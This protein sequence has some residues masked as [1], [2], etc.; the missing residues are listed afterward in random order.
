MAAAGFGRGFGTSECPA[1]FL[2]PAT[3][4][5]TLAEESIEGEEP[6]KAVSMESG[7]LHDELRRGFHSD[8]R[9]ALAEWL[10]QHLKADLASIDRKL[11]M[12]IESAKRSPSKKRIAPQQPLPLLPPPSRKNSRA[13]SSSDAAASVASFA[14]TPKGTAALFKRSTTGLTRRSE[15]GAPNAPQTGLELVLSGKPPNLSRAGTRALDSAAMSSAA[16]MAQSN[17]RALDAMVGVT[18]RA[19]ALQ[20]Y[21][22]RSRFLRS[23]SSLSVGTSS[24]SEKVITA[25]TSGSLQ[26]L[27]D[28]DDMGASGSNITRTGNRR[29]SEPD[30]KDLQ[31]AEKL[32]GWG[33]RGKVSTTLQQ[34]YDF[35]DNPESSVAARVNAVVAPFW[36]LVT[37]AMTLIQS[38]KDSPF[39]GVLAATLE[40]VVF[41]LDAYNVI[42]VLAALPL[43][44]RAFMGFVM[45]TGEVAS[46]PHAILLCGVPIIRL[47]K[48]LRRFE[49]F[50]LILSA[51]RSAAEALPVLLFILSIIALTFSMLIYLVEPRDSIE[52]IPMSLWLTIVTMS[53]VGYGDV[54][55]KTSLGHFL[56]SILIVI[57]ALYIAIP[58]GIVGNA[59]SATWEQRDK[60]LLMQRTRDRLRQW[61]FTAHD[62]PALFVLSARGGESSLDS[63]DFRKL[64]M[65]M[66]IGFSEERIL[67]LFQS[68]DEDNSGKIDDREFVRHL[69]PSAYHAI[70]QDGEDQPDPPVV[71]EPKEIDELDVQS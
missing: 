25:P 28:V 6:M 65:R 23:K 45:P 3:V 5:G 13:F 56:A 30:E 40:T 4:P 14:S 60:I 57:S 9:H 36:L 41:F 10:D 46:V 39:S 20:Q 22:E 69:F 1:A 29:S 33:Q 37:V 7:R 53:T 19:D 31:R 24:A 38:L 64:V 42:D 21:R 18:P 49:K 67:K 63:K 61:G 12:L 62:I 43:G 47:L 48:T 35:M 17:G 2:D 55:P 54:T 70:F 66:Q 50:H 27:P 15:Q 58:L 34:A 26:V 32:L 44:I 8:V 59:F 52:S 68:L 71:I 16:T 11:D 51:F